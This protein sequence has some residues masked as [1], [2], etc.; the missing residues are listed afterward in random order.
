MFLITGVNGI[1][2]ST[3]ISQLKNK[4]D[5]NTF[6]IY[7]FDERGVPSNADQQWRESETLHW[8]KT[9]KENKENT[10]V[11]GFMKF[12]EIEKS[13]SKLGVQAQIC[14]LD[15]DE[16]TISNRILGRYINSE[17]IAELE[18]VTG[19]TPEKFAQDNVWVSSKFREEAIQ[20]N[21]FIV[22]TSNSSPGEVAE[23]VV[24]WIVSK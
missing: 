21:Y 4:L 3:L 18:R 11:C 6:N 9:G 15:A 10:V 8:I 1:G 16:E 17:R 13:L 23:K 12:A 5:A 2:K 19:K 14:L 20:K 24:D 7:D 22:D